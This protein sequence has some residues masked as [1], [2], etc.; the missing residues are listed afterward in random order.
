MSTMGP[1]CP[2]QLTQQETSDDVCVGPT[3]EVA[4]SGLVQRQNEHALTAGPHIC[5]PAIFGLTNP[6]KPPPMAGRKKEV[7]QLRE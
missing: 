4:A 1:L 7:R 2:E 6:A 5:V 3:A